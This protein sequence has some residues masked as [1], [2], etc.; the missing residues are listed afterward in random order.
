LLLVAS[1]LNLCHYIWLSC[2]EFI[3]W[4]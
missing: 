2:I 4:W 1:S 3:L